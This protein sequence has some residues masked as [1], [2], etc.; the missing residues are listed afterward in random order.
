MITESLNGKVKRTYQLYTYQDKA[1]KILS[2][3]TR[4]R[5]IDYVRE[6]IDVL[7]LK[8]QQNLPKDLTKNVKKSSIRGWK[9]EIKS[10]EEDTF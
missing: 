9:L 3:K 6:A 5:Q 1:L 7:I 10:Q 8:Y 2:K 4:V